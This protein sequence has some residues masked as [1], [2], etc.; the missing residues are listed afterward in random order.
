M[1]R[2]PPT[3]IFE[4]ESNTLLVALSNKLEKDTLL[5]SRC[6]DMLSEFR[7][8]LMEREFDA[9]QNDVLVDYDSTSHYVA[10]LEDKLK[11]ANANHREAITKLEKAM[12]DLKIINVFLL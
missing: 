1:D 6:S 9:K 7:A 12:R 3:N 2:H 4:N 5:L 11:V 10:E 8:R